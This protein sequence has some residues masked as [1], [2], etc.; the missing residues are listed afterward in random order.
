M[1]NNIK[2]LINQFEMIKNLGWIKNINNGNSGVGR[3]LEKLLNIPE[4]NLEIPDF[5]GIEIKTHRIN[6]N[7]YISLFSAVP[8]GPHYHEI[9]IIKNKYG[10]P[11]KELKQY[12]VLNVTVNAK[13][14]EW[15]GANYKAILKINNQLKRIYLC[16]IDVYG[17]IIEKGTYW[18][19]DTI[20]N[21]LYR[22]MKYLAYFP[23][24]TK[25]IKNNEYFKY[26]FI[27][28]YKIINFNKFIELIENGTI[29]VAFKIGVFKSGKRK[30][31]IKDHGTT[32]KIK[33]NNLHY[34]YETIYSN[35]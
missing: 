6:S 28:I 17:N 15:F 23:V 32:F 24:T 14:L 10:Y 22:K 18:D 19:F 7:S 9:E 8:D 25:R 13:W 1:D 29:I 27:T 30:G 31:Q 16:I 35:I 34:L 26:N 4:N 21:K 2:Y 12:K 5:K 11:D 20:K 33:S 3:T